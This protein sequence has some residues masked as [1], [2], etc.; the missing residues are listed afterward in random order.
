MVTS[1]S[2]VRSIRVLTGPIA[3]L[4]LLLVLLGPKTNAQTTSY[5]NG[6]TG[7]WSASSGWSPSEVP[8]NSG[9][10]TFN[11]NILAPSSAVSMDVLNVTID[12]LTLASANSLTINAGNT[13]NLVS[14]TSN[15]YGAI[16]NNGGLRNEFSGSS[17]Q[18]FNNYGTISGTG[19]ITNASGAFNNYGTISGIAFVT[20]TPVGSFTNYGTLSGSFNNFGSAANY[21]T[22]STAGFSNEGSFSNSGTL[23]NSGSIFNFENMTSAGTLINHGTLNNELFFA[24]GGT[25]FNA[26]GASI[27]SF[28]SIG[29]FLN[30]GTIINAGTISNGDGDE[31][32][33]GGIIDNLSGG[34]LTNGGAGFLSASIVN[35]AGTVTNDGTVALA[36]FSAGT[37]TNSGTITNEG[38]GAHFS[39]GT[40][41]NSGMVRNNV[42][43]TLTADTFINTG[44]ITNQGTLDSGSFTNLGRVKISDTGLF[45]IRTNYNQFAGSTLVNGTLTANGNAVVNIF[46]GS[47]SGG[48]TVNGNVLMSGNMIAGTSGHPMTFNINGNYTQNA[49]GIFT[50][51]ISGKG[52]GQLNIS[53]T[54]A[55]APGASLNIALLGSFDPKNGTSF[56]IMDYGSEKGIFTIADPYFDHGKQEWVIT[57]YAGGDGD[58]VMLTAEASN[59]VHVPEPS[60]MLQLLVAGPLLLGVG[61]Y[62]KRKQT[63]VAS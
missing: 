25:I 15:N 53:G 42:G 12:S 46:G 3:F 33:G 2:V 20:N 30:T 32:G 27:L 40:L 57:S 54:A 1:R 36:G 16:T 48:G 51:L 24:N 28:D 22:F 60:S 49:T 21:G 56:T 39:A 52:N 38:D 14:G 7:T 4:F 61:R 8:N 63:A 62:V 19:G 13:L 58:D 45:N 43:A 44:M 59:S 31:F 55:L 41:F 5:W 10:S 9:S 11:V 6:G 18:T 35:N 26:P 47:L 37:L 50:E 17:G 29:Q 34:S 23:Y